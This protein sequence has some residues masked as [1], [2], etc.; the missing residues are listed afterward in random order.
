[1]KLCSCCPDPALNDTAALAD[2]LVSA[3]LV[4]VIVTVCADAIVAGAVYKPDDDTLPTPEGLRPHVTA[5][6]E[7][8]V[9]AAVNCWLVFAVR[10]LLPG[11]TVTLTTGGGGV[12]FTVALFDLLVSATLVAFTVTV[13][14]CWIVPGAVYNPSEVSVP[15]APEPSVQVTAVFVAPLTVA[16]NCWD[17]PPVRL[18]LLGVTEIL[19]VAF[20]EPASTQHVTK[21]TPTE[22]RISVLLTERIRIFRGAD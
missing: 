5:V 21:T 1:V 6:F 19:T 2:L 18:T 16:L 14:A 11:V 10:V 22:T 3:T 15:T 13:C 9:T 8:P 12:S 20:A 7:E 17:L 4:A